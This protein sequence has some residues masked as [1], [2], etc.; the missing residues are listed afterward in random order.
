LMSCSRSAGIP[1]C[2]ILRGTAQCLAQTQFSRE[3]GAGQ[4]PICS[5]SNS[6]NGSRLCLLARAGLPNPAVLAWIW[7][8]RPSKGMLGGVDVP[9]LRTADAPDEAARIRPTF[10]QVLHSQSLRQ[11]ACICVHSIATLHPPNGD[12]QKRR[13]RSPRKWLERAFR[14]WEMASWRTRRCFRMNAL[15]HRRLLR[16]ACTAPSAYE[17]RPQAHLSVTR[18]DACVVDAGAGSTS[19]EGPLTQARAIIRQ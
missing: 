9:K 19:L 11:T 6:Q 18:S 15:W 4:R 13:L 10:V 17:C 7:Q 16:A 5:C 2:G 14:A 3:L 8:S 12:R 1:A